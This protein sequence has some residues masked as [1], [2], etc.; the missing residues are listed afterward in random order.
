VHGIDNLWIAD[1]SVLP[2]V[3]HVNT[4]LSAILV[5]EAAARH[6]TADLRGLAGAASLACVG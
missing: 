6:V 5:G 3:P 4:N 1:A 2:V